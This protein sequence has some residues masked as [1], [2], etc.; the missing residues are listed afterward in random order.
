[1]EK[2]SKGETNMSK[3]SRKYPDSDAFHLAPNA[4]V[5]SDNRLKAKASG[6][7]SGMQDFG[8]GHVTNNA[9]RKDWSH[10][11]TAMHQDGD[12]SMNYMEEKNHI[13]GMDAKKVRRT[14]KKIGEAV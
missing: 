10:Q 1:M 3:H 7:A 2:I 13:A 12:G 5:S 9:M 11:S 8:I 4:G 6:H 14:F